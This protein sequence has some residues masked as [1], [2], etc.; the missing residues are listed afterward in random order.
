MKY[1][2]LEWRRIS[3]KREPISFQTRNTLG[4]IQKG[5]KGGR[6][7]AKNEVKG[8]GRGTKSFLPPSTPTISKCTLR[9][10]LDG[11]PLSKTDE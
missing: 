10:L 11:E 5:D 8:R 2:S 4:K 7:E 3:I 9:R 1:A 6:N